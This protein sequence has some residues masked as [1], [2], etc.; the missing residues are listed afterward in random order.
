[1][2]V[3]TG[4][5]TDRNGAQAPPAN[6]HQK[7]PPLAKTLAEIGAEASYEELWIDV[8]EIQCDP[9]YQRDLSDRRVTKMAA[10]WTPALCDPIRVNM[11]DDNTIW[12]IDGQHRWAAAARA[13]VPQI[14]ATVFYGLTLEQEAAMFTLLQQ[15]RTGIRFRDAFR[16]R[17][18]AGEPIAVAIKEAV[19]GVGCQLDYTSVSRAHNA[20]SALAVMEQIYQAGG[21]AGLRLVLRLLREVWPDDRDALS[22]SMIVGLYILLR[23]QSDT[24]DYGRLTA[25]LRATTPNKIQRAAQA[26]RTQVGGSLG[27]HIAIAMAMEYNKRLQKGQI[28][29][30][31]LLKAPRGLSPSRRLEVAK[32]DAGG[33][34]R[35][36]LVGAEGRT[37]TATAR[38]TATATPAGQVQGR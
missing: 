3:R 22:E 26:A 13:G 18:T 10:E 24:I 4:A 23:E 7:P 35:R 16:A 5:G 20:V 9:E 8:A 25:Q 33:N 38:T 1:M 34:L 31:L 36:M 30:G 6:G 37:R 12:V 17:I 28:D 32:R 11:R 29:L 19:E 21:A 27:P 2:A 15:G 14:K